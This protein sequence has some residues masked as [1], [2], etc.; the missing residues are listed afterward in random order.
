VIALADQLRQD[1]RHAVRGLRR[2]P[3]FTLVVALTLALGIGTN[4]AI[5]SVVDQLLLRPLP[6]PDGDQIVRVHEQNNARGTHSDVNPGNWLDWQRQSQTLA[7]QA[8]W[9]PAAATLTGIGEPE[10]LQ[11][12]LVSHE[13]FPLLGVA[14]LVGRT[15]A[16]DDDRP[17]APRVVVLS[18]ALWQR[19]FN[20]D[21]A[22][23]GR[24]IRLNEEPNEV[25]GVMPPGFLF[26]FQETDFW[27]AFR[28][29]RNAQWRDIA[30]RFMSVVARMKP[31]VTL[32]DAEGEMVTIATGLQT[33]H[34]RQQNMSVDLVPLRDELV[35][36][37]QG[38]LLVLYG[39]V[40]LLL[41]IACL[42][43][44]NLLLARARSRRREI[45]V[46]SSIGAGRIA[47][48]RQFVVESVVLAAI[49]GALGLLFARWSLNGLL[50]LAPPDVVPVTELR[51]DRR[52]LLYAVGV[53]VV[54]GIVVGLV[55]AI[56]TLRRSL[57]DTLRVSSSTITHASRMRQA[58]VVGQVAMTVVLLS[59]AGLLMRTV[60]ELTVVDPGFDR[61]DLLTMQLDLPN[62]RYDE[63]RTVEFYRQLRERVRQLPGVES[64][65]AAVTRPVVGPPIGRTGVQ[66]LGQPELPATAQP[67][68]AT[69]VVT[70]D[71]FRTLGI[72]VVAGREFTEADQT[73][74]AGLSFIVNEAFVSQILQ[75]QD[76]LTVMMTF[77]MQE[78]NPYA[79]IIGVVG[80]VADGSVS[81]PAQPTVFYNQRQIPIDAM[82]LF[83]R[84][85]G[86]P[87]VARAAIDAIHELDPNLAIANV[88]TMDTALGESLG[89]E[90]LIALVSTMFGLS[91]LVLASLGLYGLLAFIVAER[92]KEIGLR[93]ALGARLGELLRGVL[94]GGLFLVLVGAII[95]IAAAAAVSRS[96]AFLFY[97]VTPYDPLTYAAVLALLAL[98]AMV[99]TLVPARRAATVNPVVA[100]RAD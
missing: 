97:G 17:D 4:T 20:A 89:R 63:T 32:A 49:G 53:S 6:Y 10:R 67:S 56:A 11:A 29:D 59:G 70:P 36:D 55:P 22:V 57:A 34:P 18:H 96:I 78:E 81:A 16:P 14:P 30:G 25:I 79:P 15:I 87:G 75:G 12:L 13:F 86:A 64:A 80:D 19:R 76:P 93:I 54:T 44:A 3:G 2:T 84:A 60:A 23:V 77:G 99:A 90:R 58:L 98:V 50:A 37:V 66:V 69:R 91:G 71:Y 43:V 41:A 1:I 51:L 38:A 47:L 85:P 7:A 39:A 28:L 65:A 31:G 26:L 21:P 100:L 88:Q 82:V 83:L 68:A 42:N 73:P 9:D 5:F 46:R 24:I 92:T 74:D 61:R 45:A 33:V 8:A 35:G 27:T 94:G 40:V 72:P 62:G 52:I 95:G 48:V